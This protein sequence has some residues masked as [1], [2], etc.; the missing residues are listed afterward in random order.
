MSP[1]TG[2]QRTALVFAHPEPPRDRRRIRPVFLPFAGCPHRCLFCD[3][4]AQTGVA[5]ASLEAILKTLEQGLRQAQDQGAEP[6]ELG[7]Y[8]G[9]FTALP[10]DWPERFLQTIRPFR[11]AGLVTRVRC[12]T[13]PDAL[14]PRRLAG[15]KDLGLDLLE[16]GI[17]SFDDQALAASGRSYSQETALAACR[18][19][20]QAGLGLGLQL[21]PGLPGDRPGVFRSDVEIAA[22]LAP[23]CARLYPCLVLEGTELAALW[24]NGG[25][26]PWSLARA[27]IELSLALTRLWRAGVPVIRLGLAPEP[28]L[29]ARVLAGP[30]HPA[31]GQEARSLALLDH[32]RRQISRLGRRPLGLEVPAG[33]QG[34]FWGQG[35]GLRRAYARLGLP[36]ERVAASV[37]GFFRL[38]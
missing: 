6:C 22:R 8:G 33:S 31:L 3:Q 13:R 17:Q 32:L 34:E 11:A 30:A 12:S 16:L 1:G 5:P 25:Y 15:L 26:A 37:D 38:V 35:G 23:D 27:R 21:L 18:I 9:T 7:L 36:R 19:V 28:G 4:K 14:E 10:G 20:R 29:A 2:P 24:R